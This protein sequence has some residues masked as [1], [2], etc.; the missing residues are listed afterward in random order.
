MF[1][2]PLSALVI[3]SGMWMY[4]FHAFARAFQHV[5]WHRMYCHHYC[6]CWLS[7][8]HDHIIRFAGPL[9]GRLTIFVLPTEVLLNMLGHLSSRDLVRLSLTCKSL[10]ML[11]ATPWLWKVCTPKYQLTLADCQIITIVCVYV[12]MR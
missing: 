7:F 4:C 1:E 8:Q 5:C 12:C 11:C 2:T 9:S 10:S 3:Y 6:V